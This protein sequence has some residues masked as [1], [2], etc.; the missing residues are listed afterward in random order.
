MDTGYLLSDRRERDIDA[1][2]IP[3][4]TIHDVNGVRD[5][6]PLADESRTRPEARRELGGIGASRLLQ[7]AFVR[8]QQVTV[9]EDLNLVDRTTS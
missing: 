3:K 5:T 4:A 6:V 2:L 1:I 8:W 7:L 9:C